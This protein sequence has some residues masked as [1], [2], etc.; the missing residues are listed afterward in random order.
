MT[1]QELRQYQA[2]LALM[3]E[4]EIKVE[5]DEVRK[6][7]KRKMQKERVIVRKAKHSSGVS[8]IGG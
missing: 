6:S 2:K 3:S 8:Y 5:W 4:A 7:L 1:K